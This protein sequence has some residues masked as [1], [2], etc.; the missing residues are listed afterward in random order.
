VRGGS[1]RLALAKQGQQAFV[2]PSASPV[3]K[4]SLKTRHKEAAE[5]LDNPP[6][7]LLPDL[8]R[9]GGSRSSQAAFCL[10]NYS[11][12]NLGG[13]KGWLWECRLR[14]SSL[15]QRSKFASGQRPMWDASGVRP[16]AARP[17]SGPTS[18]PHLGPREP[19][20][21][22]QGWELPSAPS[23]QQPLEPRSM[24]LT[25]LLS[26]VLHWYADKPC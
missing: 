19:Q 18:V 17:A 15:T 8:S 16:P 6:S 14:A 7:P 12:N 9:L 10:L 1:R 25:R 23:S 5:E 2:Y 21:L 22:R 24:A 11:N 26:A 4:S 3:T 13:D 20:H